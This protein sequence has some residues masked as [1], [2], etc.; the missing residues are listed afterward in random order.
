[1]A[2]LTIDKA[3]NASVYVTL[4]GGKRKPVRLGKAGRQRADRIRAHLSEL[5]TAR[6]RGIEPAASARAW[7][8]G[9]KGKL[10]QRV[11][12]VGLCVAEDH[13]GATLGAFIDG[14]LRQRR[15]IKPGTL[16]V[17]QQARRHV[18]RFLG[19]DRALATVT[20]TDADAY[21]AHLIEKGRARATVA[22]WCRTA[23]HF[24]DVAKRRR[25]ID[26]NP[27]AHIRDGVHGNAARRRFIPADDIEKVIDAAPDPQWKL[28][29]ALARYGGLRVPSEALALTWRD[30]DFEHGRFI[31]RASKTEHRAGGGVRVVP[32]FPELAERFQAVFDD[33]AEGGQHVI[34]LYRDAAQN[35]R[36][37]FVRY[38]EAAGL[39]PWP[40]PWQNLRATRAT[41]LADRFPSHVCA[42]WL[43]H[44]EAI[45]DEFYRQVTDE[46]FERATAADEKAVRKPVRAGGA[47]RRTEH[48]NPP[49]KRT[50]PHENT[51]ET[52]EVGGVGF[53]PT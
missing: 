4:P 30:V 18:V 36:T 46:H 41:E 50:K 32:M 21:R 2:T 19:E 22:K 43:G 20:P 1:M 44:T 45:A 5:E 51:R 37:Q 40:K 7:V 39:T 27:F 24:F 11:A 9:I 6:L 53:E 28:L 26:D 16:K 3:G 35:L 14:Y 47:C 23:R 13:T 10:R 48:A 15:D 38:I 25:M 31:V 34:T 29:I 17:Y 12:A 33:A 8:A 49:S 52:C 42:A